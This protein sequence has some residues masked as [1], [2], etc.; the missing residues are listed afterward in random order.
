MLTYLYFVQHIRYLTNYS[1]TTKK[2]KKHPPPIPRS[3]TPG[4]GAGTGTDN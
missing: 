1:N 3:T 2:K 4:L